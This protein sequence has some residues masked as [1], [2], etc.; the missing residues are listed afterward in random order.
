MDFLTVTSKG[1]ALALLD[2]FGDAAAVMGGGTIIA[3][4][5]RRCGGGAETV[6]HVGRAVDLAGLAPDW[7]GAAVTLRQL[8]V[9][10]QLAAYDGLRRA[11][12]LSGSWQIQGV[13]TIGG[14]LCDAAP[15]ADLVPPLL[16][17]GATVTLESLREGS[18]ILPLADFLLGPHR[19][20]RGAHEMLTGVSLEARPARTADAF[21]KVTRRGGMEFSTVSLAIRLSLAEDGETVEEARIAVGAMAPLPFR[22]EAAEGLL[23]GQRLS[24]TLLAEAGQAALIPAAP[25]TDVRASAEYRRAVLPR[26]LARALRDSARAAACPPGPPPCRL[27]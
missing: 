24:D 15:Y 7:I 9:A 19:V 10:P 8:A 26:L 16:V 4:R 6:I 13:G 25:Q 12:A 5:L 18:R 14:N 21:V 27:P 23:R 2:R 11:A 3:P 22:A 17:H 1:E 20:A